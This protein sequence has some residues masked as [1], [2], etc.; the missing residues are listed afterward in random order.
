MHFI[1]GLSCMP[2]FGAKGK[3]TTDHLLFSTSKQG[4]NSR[5]N[6]FSSK[7][8]NK[9]LEE[10]IVMLNSWL[11]RDITNYT[12]Q[13]FHIDLGLITIRKINW[14]HL[15][16][17]RIHICNEKDKITIFVL[18]LK[19]VLLKFFDIFFALLLY[20]VLP[21]QLLFNKQFFMHSTSEKYLLQH[22]IFKVCI[23][24]P[25]V[26]ILEFTYLFPPGKLDIE[27]L[28]NISLGF[29]LYDRCPRSVINSSK[30]MSIH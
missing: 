20:W 11:Q 12:P 24:F 15:Y 21:I 8:C 25:N 28:K 27:T 16:I 23:I 1:S 9:R 10:S 5:T 3:L 30:V 7:Q 14:L 13:V 18:Y 6:I 2:N 22:Y 17:T 29:F 26:S 4:A 19:I